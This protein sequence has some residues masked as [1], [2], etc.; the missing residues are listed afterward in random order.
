MK[1][2]GKIGSNLSWIY[3]E[4]AN[5]RGL[6]LSS[7]LW[8]VS[9]IL[10]CPCHDSDDVEN[11]SSSCLALQIKNYFERGFRELEIT[12]HGQKEKTYTIQFLA[13][14]NNSREDEIT[15]KNFVLFIL[16]L[17]QVIKMVIV[18]KP[19]KQTLDSIIGKWSK[20]GF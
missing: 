13:Y 5:Y 15:S 12:R 14:S 1:A 11:F 20:S 2:G 17:N 9:P 8:T 4:P 10:E 16:F 19:R 7:Q 6:L 3:T 18:E